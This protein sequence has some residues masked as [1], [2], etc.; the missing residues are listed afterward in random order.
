MTHLPEAVHLV[1]QAPVLYLPW[2]G[3]P[4]LFAQPRHGRILGRVAV[5][6]PLLRFGPRARSEIGADIR[7]RPQHLGVLEELVCAEPVA[8]DGA[9]GHLEPWRSLIPGSDAVAPVI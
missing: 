9:P 5:L 8:L 6:H 4:V 2:L 1:T 3:T 7:L